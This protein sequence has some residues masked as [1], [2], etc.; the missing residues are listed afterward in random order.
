MEKV[1]PEFAH[2]LVAVPFAQREEFHLIVNLH[3]AGINVRHL[4]AVYCEMCL[5]ND[6]Y[7]QVRILV[8]MITRVVKNHVNKLLRDTVRELCHPGEAF[9]RGVVIEYLNLVFGSSG[10]SAVHWSEHIYAYLVKKF[11]PFK[12]PTGNTLL[13]FLQHCAESVKLKDPKCMIFEHLSEALGLNWV[14]STWETG[15]T[16]PRLF[17]R[18]FPFTETDLRALQE[19]LKEEQ[20]AAYSTGHIWK[21][22]ALET[23]NEQERLR[24][25]QLAC[26]QYHNALQCAP[27]DKFCLR[28]LASCMTAMGQHKKAEHFYESALRVDPSDPHTLFKCA[29]SFDLRGM[30]DEAENYYLRALEMAPTNPMFLCTY[31]DFLWTLRKDNDFARKLYEKVLVVAPHHTQTLNNYAVFLALV[32]KEYDLA[33]QHF[34]SSVSDDAEVNLRHMANICTFLSSIRPN[35]LT[36]AEFY[37]HLQTMKQL[38]RGNSL[39]VAEEV[40]QLCAT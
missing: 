17:Q 18:H 7:W 32:A 39:V 25:L 10:P 20:I 14:P 1:I 40:P 21:S 22:K 24:F 15:V 33:E 19:R 36:Y 23:K 2:R 28:S 4:G 38:K 8:E 3:E 13:S 5:I 12:Y 29:A 26:Q 34:A 6:E 9:Y 16:N 37:A 35:P 31:A 30:L 27:D 11:A